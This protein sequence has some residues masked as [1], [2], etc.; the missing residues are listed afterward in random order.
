MSRIE[1]HL[2]FLV[3]IQSFKAASSSSHT[4]QRG[5][6]DCHKLQLLCIQDDC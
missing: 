1:K 5:E 4:H 3:I 6:K 2:V